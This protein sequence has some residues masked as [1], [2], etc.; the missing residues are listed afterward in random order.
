MCG[1]KTFLGMS[2]KLLETTKEIFPNPGVAVVGLIAVAMHLAQEHD[3]PDEFIQSALTAL[4]QAC[5]CQQDFI[6]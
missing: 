5:N 3:I 1:D 6:Q 4:D 2:D